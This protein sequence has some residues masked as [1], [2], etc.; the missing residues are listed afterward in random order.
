MTGL[1]AGG[2]RRALRVAAAVPA[3]SDFATLREACRFAEMGGFDAYTRPDHLL[4]EGV[5]GPPGA[6]LLECFTT[7]AALIPSTTRLRFVQTVAC[8]SFRNPALLAKMVASLDVISGGRMELG[9]GAGW[10]RQEY[11]AYGYAFPPPDV[12]LAQLREA[13][14]VV[15]LLWTGGPV[16]YD[17]GHYT[18]RRAVCAPRPAQVPRP[19]ILVGG[20]GKGLLAVAAA[21][22]DIVN[23]VPPTSHGVSSQDAVRRFTCEGFQRKGRR[24]REFAAMAGRDPA[25]LSLSAMFFVQI[26]ASETQTHTLV[27]GVAARYRLTFAEAERMP[28]FVMGTP[29]QLRERLAERIELLGVDYVVLQFAGLE[30]L[31]QFA[32]EVLP[33]LR[34]GA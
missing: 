32:A 23:I 1:P 12:R 10:L 13:L 21:E 4:S 8:N 9:L 33:A 20:G 17:G 5:L 24:V 31:A 2:S 34:P 7:I 6:P 15:K 28:L 16:D 14:Q 25:L 22:A 26:A 19:P 27:D 3:T 29:A 18:L 11:D 30:P